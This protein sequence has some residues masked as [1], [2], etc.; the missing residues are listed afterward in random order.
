A[1]AAVVPGRKIPALAGLAVLLVGLHAYGFW[2]M[3]QPLAE[4]GSVRVGLVQGGV[5]QHDKWRPELA[6][7]NV[8]RHLELTRQASERGARLVVWPES[9]VPFYYDYTPAMAERL[10]DEVRRRGI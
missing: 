5:A 7:Q 1:Y 8:D 2:V 3:A 10:R 4:T 9:A 6:V